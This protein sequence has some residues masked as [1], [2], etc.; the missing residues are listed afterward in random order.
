MN[1]VSP[2]PIVT[3]YPQIS[4]TIVVMPSTLRDPEL[5]FDKLWETFYNGYPFFDLRNVDWKKQYDTYRPKVTQLT[6]DDELFDIF[7]EMLDPLDDGHV[8]L[9]GRTG[10]GRRKRSFNPEP[11]PRFRQEFSRREIRHL[12]KTTQKT[13]SSRGFGQTRGNFCLDASLLSLPR[14][15]LHSD[16]RIGGCQKAKTERSVGQNFQ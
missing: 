9:K 1:Q 10:P 2:G 14:C 13:L 16:P 8:E 6:T 4:G 3:E 7:C 15:C 12:F 11:E 5:N